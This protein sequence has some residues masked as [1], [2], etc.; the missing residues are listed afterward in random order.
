LSFAA[1]GD[2]L[3]HV[4]VK[5]SADAANRKDDKGRSLN[6]GGYDSLFDDLTSALS[7]ADFAYA[8]LETPVSLSGDAGTKEFHFNAPPDLLEALKTAGIKVVSV[9]NNHVYDQGQKG[10]EETLNELDKAGLPYAGAGRGDAEAHRGARLE[11]NGIRVAVLGA[12]QFFN[13]KDEKLGD[14]RSARAN[15]FDEKAI[16]EAIRT[17]RSDSDF[18]IVAAHWGEEYQAKPRASEVELAHDLFEAGADVILGT[19]PHVLQPIE[20]YRAADGRTCMVIYSLGNFVSNQSRN[21]A[22]GVS[23][24]KV[25]DTRDGALL[26]FAAVKRDYGEGGVRVE[27]AD[28]SF[29]PLWTENDRRSR[30]G[31]EQPE[32]KVVGIARALERTRA[33]LDA[34]K[35]ALGGKPSKAEQDRIAALKKR[36]GLYERRREII[37]ARLGEDFIF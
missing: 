6:H 2:V 32:I 27:L 11:K 20:I 1:V 28:V 4:S 9:A 22:W 12:T 31:K 8:N 13:T 34:L 25:G 26:R 30:H 36:I 7:A 10:L 21:Y 37:A 15:R 29:L 19:H 16:G 3:P 23:P 14:P 18:V 35:A 24:E 17:A 5:R 33:E